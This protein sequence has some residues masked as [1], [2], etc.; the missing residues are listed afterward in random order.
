MAETMKQDEQFTDRVSKKTTQETLEK[1]RI[2]G[3]GQINEETGIAYHDGRQ[4]LLPR[5]MSYKQAAKLTNAQAISMEEVHNFQKTF[6]YRP[7][8]GAHA[9]Q[10]TL[11][12]IFGLSGTGKAIHT[13]FGTKPPEY[14]NVK[15]GPG[16]EIKVPW[17]QIDFPPVEGTF[18]TNMVNDPTYGPLFH[19]SLH[20]PKKYEPEIEGLWIAIEDML[21]RNSIYKGKAIV[22]VGRVT[23]DGYDEPVFLDPYA[24]DPAKVAYKQEVFEKLKTSVWGLIE[25]AELQRVAGVPLGKKTLLYGP[26]GTGKSLAGGLTARVAVEQRLDVH[27]GQD[28]GGG[29]GQGPEDR[30][31]LRP[32]CRLPGGR[33]QPHRERARRRWPSSW[34][35]S[36]ASPARARR[37]WC[38]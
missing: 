29:P 37:S 8:D 24:I 33:R 10:A 32:G 11:K 1:L 13:M 5:G 12:E 21:R 28:L 16:Q 3:G 17:G 30:R 2:L 31:A 9:L 38:S 19:L 23:R 34:R 27:P 4:I 22:G 6:P 15:V 18:H 35:C 7:W 14:R 20:A 36:T 26:Y 25:T